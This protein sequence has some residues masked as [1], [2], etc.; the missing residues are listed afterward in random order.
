[1]RKIILFIFLIA[2]NAYARDPITVIEEKGFDRKYQIGDNKFTNWL[3]GNNICVDFLL[4]EAKIPTEDICDKAVFRT[5]T[6]YIL[7]PITVTGLLGGMGTGITALIIQNTNLGYVSLGLF[8]LFLISG[9]LQDHM[10]STANALYTRAITRYNYPTI[11]DKL[12]NKNL[13][14]EK[15]NFGELKLTVQF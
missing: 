13:S 14:L 2:T 8:G 11:E 9:I 1:M 4:K 12:Q 5:R 6:V 15:P 7:N 10:N 3:D